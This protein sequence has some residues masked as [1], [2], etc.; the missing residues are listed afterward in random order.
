MPVKTNRVQGHLVMI[1]TALVLNWP[2]A[3]A[4]NGESALYKGTWTG[5]YRADNSEWEKANYIVEESGFKLKANEEP[6]LS[7]TIQI[8]FLPKDDWRFEARD[9][10]SDSKGV[11]FQFGRGSF[12]LK[13]D[14]EKNTDLELVGSCEPIDETAGSTTSEI[15]MVPPQ[16]EDNT[17]G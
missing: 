2:A 3:Q 8:N 7:L 14:L 13:C 6:D 1:A 11:K 9:L 15:R 4:E 12:Q 10:E 16:A 17:G 5:F